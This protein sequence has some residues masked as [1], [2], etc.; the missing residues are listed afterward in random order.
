[1][2]N[3]FL[4][5]GVLT[6][7]LGLITACHTQVHFMNNKAQEQYKS[8]SIHKGKSNFFIGGLGQTDKINA[9]EICGKESNIQ[10]VETRLPFVYGLIGALTLSIY[11]PREYTVY[12]K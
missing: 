12:C 7:L 5:I 11:T 10:A 6:V 4:K 8:G 1:M 2:K 3:I 9:V